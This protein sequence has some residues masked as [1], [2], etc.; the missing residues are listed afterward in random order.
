M[1]RRLPYKIRTTGFYVKV[2]LLNFVALFVVIKLI[3]YIQ[4]PEILLGKYDNVDTA[5]IIP[6]EPILKRD[7]PTSHGQFPRIPRVIHQTWKNENIPMEFHKNVRSFVNYNPEF[8]YYFWTDKTARKLI[9]TKH[10]YVLETFDNYVEP[11]RKADMLRFVSSFLN[12]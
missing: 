9:E 8:E 2:V 1:S 10:P 4:E 7:F 11:V 3:K 12:C 6:F 5:G